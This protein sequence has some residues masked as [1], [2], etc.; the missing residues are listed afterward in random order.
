[1]AKAKSNVEFKRV[2][3]NLPVHIYNQVVQYAEN[4]G[5]NISSAYIFL[6]SQALDQKSMYAQ[7]PDLLK[8]V[9]SANQL[10][11]NDESK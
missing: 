10:S 8:L 11:M 6:V 9:N 1:M 2:N 4:L 3:I 7:L 5:V